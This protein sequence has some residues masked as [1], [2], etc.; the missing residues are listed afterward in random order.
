MFFLLTSYNDMQVTFN[1][2]INFTIRLI[3]VKIHKNIEKTIQ[4]VPKMSIL[5]G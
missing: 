4:K 2:S 5:C 3:T 1:I